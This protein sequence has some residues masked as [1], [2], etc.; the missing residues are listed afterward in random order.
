MT[1]YIDNDLVGTWTWGSFT[2]VFKDDG[3]ATLTMDE[4]KY[5]Q[6]NDWCVLKS[7]SDKPY[8]IVYMIGT[9]DDG[10]SVNCYFKESENNGWLGL[11]NRVGEFVRRTET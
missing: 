7:D 9:S 1:T 8:R 10:L 4:Y 2:A 11:S 3:T 5:E 6:S